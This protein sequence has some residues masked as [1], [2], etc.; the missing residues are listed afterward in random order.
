[1][2]EEMIAEHIEFLKK[3][4]Q[5]GKTSVNGEWLYTNQVPQW[6]WDKCKLEAMLLKPMTRYFATMQRFFP[7]KSMRQM[8]EWQKM[9]GP[10][11]VVIEMYAPERLY[12]QPVRIEDLMK[13]VK[14]LMAETSEAQL[15]DDHDEYMMKLHALYMVYGSTDLN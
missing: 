7:T 14:E 6:F 9:Y 12:I 15:R 1:M 3:Q 10:K 5:N 11:I 2:L 4:E 13:S 8:L